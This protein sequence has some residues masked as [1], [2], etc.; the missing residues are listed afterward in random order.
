M[1]AKTIDPGEYKFLSAMAFVVVAV[2][3]AGGVA[4]AASLDGSKVLQSAYWSEVLKVAGL[5]AVPLVAIA[6]RLPRAS[7]STGW[8]RP[9]RVMV[10]LAFP[11][12]VGTIG[13]CINRLAQMPKDGAD[14]SDTLLY[15]TSIGLGLTLAAVAVGVTADVLDKIDPRPAA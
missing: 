14:P 4:L 9:A 8:E 13:I 1:A 15:I 10:F 7:G 12:V 2:G 5:S 11:L 6:V 3:L